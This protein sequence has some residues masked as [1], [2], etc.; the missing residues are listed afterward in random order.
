MRLFVSIDLPASH[1]E[2][3]AD[4]QA[5]LAR[6][7]GLRM[8]DPKQAHATLKF[9]GEV[10]TSRVDEIIAR[11]ERAV[12]EAEVSPFVAQLEGIDVFPNPDY[13][14]VVWIGVGRGGAEMA[15]LAEATERQLVD[16]GFDPEEHAFTPHVTIARMDHGGGKRHVQRVVAERS[17]TIE[18]FSVDSIALTESTLT[19]NGPVYETVVRVALP[20]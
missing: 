15:A 9:L 1:A 18:P 10:D 20:E 3:I 12:E 13:I 8:T 6:A 5:E 14:R 19:S 4:V 16:A 17:P 7:E 2:E 11:L